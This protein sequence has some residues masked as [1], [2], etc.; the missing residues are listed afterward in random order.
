[1]GMSSR[2][3]SRYLHDVV[4]LLNGSMALFYAQTDRVPLLAIGGSGP[5][6]AAQRTMPLARTGKM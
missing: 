1:M 2:E 4:G 5:G 3:W 6:D